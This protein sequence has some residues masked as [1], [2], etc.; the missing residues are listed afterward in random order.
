[1]PTHPA[2]AQPTPTP[3]EAERLARSVKWNG[4][5]N[6]DSMIGGGEHGVEARTYAGL[7]H[8]IIQTDLAPIGF[9]SRRQLNVAACGVR[10][11][12]AGGPVPMRAE[13]I[14]RRLEAGTLCREC[15]RNTIGEIMAV[16][17]APVFESEE[18]QPRYVAYAK[19][20][21]RTPADQLAFDRETHG[22]LRNVVAWDW[23]RARLKEWRALK[24]IKRD[25]LMSAE[26]DEFDAWLAARDCDCAPCC[27]SYTVAGALTG[28]RACRC[29]I[30][31]RAQCVGVGEVRS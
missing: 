26:N 27:N 9:G 1:M 23:I 17:P 13:Q 5:T 12:V 16:A 7:D 20:H 22:A 29:P 30:A 10:F 15:L 14:A 25:Y 8:A 3:T 21:G 31:P 24:G 18:W 6:A 4:F 11:A 28:H 19:A 2:A